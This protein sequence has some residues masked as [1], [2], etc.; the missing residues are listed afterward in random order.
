MTEPLLVNPFDFPGLWD[1]FTLDGTDMPGLCVE[2]AGA[3]NPRIWDKKKGQG[4]SGATL[5]FSGTDLSEFTVKFQLIT[6]EDWNN[7]HAQKA[8]FKAPSGKN[9]PSLSCYHPTLD[10]LPEPIT[11]VVIKDPSSPTQNGDQWFY[12]I[13]FSQDRRAKPAGGK[14]TG[15]T[16]YTGGTKKDAQD[17]AI[18]NLTA[19]LNGMAK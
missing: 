18:D 8:R 4:S 15:T 11:A 7:Y 12:S 2:V 17:A 14:S 10:L 5:V 3:S 13:K 19:Q 9:P 1:V 16:D 6:V